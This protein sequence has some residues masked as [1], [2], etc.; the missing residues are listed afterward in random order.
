MAVWESLF[1][2]R[3]VTTLTSLILSISSPKNSTLMAYP[4][5]KQGISQLFNLY[6][7]HVT[8]KGYVVTLIAYIY[9][10]SL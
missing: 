4:L 10:L 5:N 3:P 6:P 2:A 9:K 8:V 7:E 1:S